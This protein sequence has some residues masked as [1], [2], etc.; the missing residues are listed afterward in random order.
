MTYF[1][2][3]TIAILIITKPN[4]NENLKLKNVLLENLEKL[5]SKV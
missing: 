3:E 2:L 4:S 5:A 1:M